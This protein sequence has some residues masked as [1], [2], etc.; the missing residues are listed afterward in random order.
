MK[1]GETQS[2]IAEEFAAKFDKTKE[3]IRD[4]IKRYLKKLS[5]SDQKEVL[6]EAKKNPE[7]YIH[8]KKMG[9]VY[10]KIDKIDSK[11]PS[12]YNIKAQNKKKKKGKGQ[13]KTRNQYE[14]LIQKLQNKDPYFSVDL[15][16]QLLNCLFDEM[17]Q[18]GV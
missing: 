9:D 17:E 10:R 3:S 15:G 13:K 4:R 11:E 6:R 5:P 1:Q 14:W 2:K 8:F 16:V 18:E 7:N 12:I